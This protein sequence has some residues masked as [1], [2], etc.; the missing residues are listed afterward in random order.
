L[1]L[2]P[3]A[4]KP[5]IPTG[6]FGLRSNAWKEENRDKNRIDRQLSISNPKVERRICIQYSPHRW[7]DPRPVGYP[8]KQ[9]ISSTD[10]YDV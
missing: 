6:F 3:Q 4:I 9:K 1:G 8:F 5:D 7:L 2:K 10:R